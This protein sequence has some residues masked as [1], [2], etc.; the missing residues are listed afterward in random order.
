MVLFK[1][2]QNEIRQ[3]KNKNKQSTTTVKYLSRLSVHQWQRLKI[4]NNKIS[5][6]LFYLIKNNNQ[7]CK[8]LPSFLF[9][10]FWS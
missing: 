8:L 6:F 9:L 2:N 5:N 4:Q 1:T 3:I 7:N 10:I